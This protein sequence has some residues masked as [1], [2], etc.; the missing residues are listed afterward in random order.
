VTATPLHLPRQDALK[1]GVYMAIAMASFVSND[2]LV[3]L[4]SPELPVG[5]LIFWRGVFASLILLAAL[6]ING[7][8]PH[9]PMAASP[10]VVLRSL[11]DG[12]ATI[13]FITALVHMPIANLTSISHAAP[14]VVTALAAIFLKEH[15]GWRRT[16]AILVGFL[17]VLLI[18]RPSSGGFDRY[19]LM[20]VGVVAGVALR[21]ILTRRIPSS[22]P[23]LVV[24]FAN[25]ALVVAAAFV[26]AQI[27]GG[28]EMP[29]WHQLLH[30]VAAGVFLSLG[31]L[32]MVQTLRFADI[33]ASASIR[34]TGVLWAL[35]SGIVVF[36]E[37]PHRLALV[38]IVLIVASGIYTLHRESKLKRLKAAQ[39]PA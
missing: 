5:T 34:Y 1:G 38:G 30:L 10:K 2:T 39:T 18:T 25:S 28:L 19:A 7:S 22:V 12:I 3:K 9:L 26:L 21:D 15:V 27:E 6:C 13:L 4:L 16:T 32:F 31:Y 17:G 14:L 23:A 33:S 29:R 37:I 8:L 36:G 20:G 35:L 11:T 24:A